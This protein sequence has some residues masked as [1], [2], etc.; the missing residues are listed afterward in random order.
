MDKWKD[1]ELE[2]M[3]VGGNARCQDF[4]DEQPD[5]RPNMSFREKWNSKAAALLR[6]KIS[7]ESEGRLW[8][9]EASPAQNWDASSGS[10]AGSGASGGMKSSYSYS[11]HKSSM[12]QDFGLN[13]IDISYQ[14]DDYFGDHAIHSD[15]DRYTGFGN[16]PNQPQASQN[17]EMLDSALS[18]LSSGWS[19]LSRGAMQAASVAKDNAVKI[20]QTAVAKASEVSGTVSEKVKDG[21]LLTG[22]GSSISSLTSKAAE[23]SIKGWQDL[24]SVFGERSGGGMSPTGDQ[25]NR[26]AMRTRS[27]R[28]SL[29]GGGSNSSGQTDASSRSKDGLFDSSGEQARGYSSYQNSSAMGS[30]GTYS[31]IDGR[32]SESPF[33]DI[34]DTSS[35]RPTPSRDQQQ[36]VTRSNREGNTRSSLNRGAASGSGDNSSSGQSAKVQQQQRRSATSASKQQGDSW[37]SSWDDNAWDLLNS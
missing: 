7:T 9:P 29:L 19:F 33:G 31:S 35:G 12:Q 8:S 5:Y 13:E 2:K 6:D 21:S 32:D 16:T 11:A 18:S 1:N 3:K 22:V 17:N 4:F 10:M 14:K 15:R 34:G 26:A 24:G 30:S 23:V 36:S 27:E 37:S 28:S 20:S 25:E